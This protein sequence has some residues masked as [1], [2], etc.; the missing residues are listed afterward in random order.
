VVVS[1]KPTNKKP[2]KP[3]TTRYTAQDQYLLAFE[4]LTSDSKL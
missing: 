4:R 3:Q 2:L 1:T